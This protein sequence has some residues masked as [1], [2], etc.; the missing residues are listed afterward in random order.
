MTCGGCQGLGAH[1][2]RCSTQPGYRWRIAYDMADELGDIIGSSD[3]EAA[4]RAYA[5]AGLMKKKW[6]EANG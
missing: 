2:P 3:I 6:R 4:N 1:S 5:I